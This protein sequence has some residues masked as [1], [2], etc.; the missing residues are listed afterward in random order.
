LPA[1]LHAALTVL[2]AA[3]AEHEETSK[4]LFYVAGAILA[5]FAVAISAIGIARHETFPPSKAV[6]RGVM[7]LAAVL[8]AFTMASA[9]ITG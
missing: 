3:P 6:A 4:T 2:A 5:L 8:V 9:I 1:V 7:A